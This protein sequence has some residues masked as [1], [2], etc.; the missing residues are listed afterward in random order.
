[1][2]HQPSSCSFLARVA[3]I[4]SRPTCPYTASTQSSFVRCIHCISCYFFTFV[5]AS[6]WCLF[7]SPAASFSAVEATDGVR[8]APASPQRAC[9]GRRWLGVACI[10]GAGRG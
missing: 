10:S 5:L 7:S 1:M 3:G 8:H 2:K 9:D 4:H 6:S